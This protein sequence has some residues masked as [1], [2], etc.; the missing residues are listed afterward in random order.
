MRVNNDNSIGRLICF[1]GIDGSGKSTHL[2]LVRK[3]L[4]EKG[5]SVKALIL[6]TQRGE[7]F[8]CLEPL[9]GQIPEQLYCDLFMFQRYL[10][11]Q[12]RLRNELARNSVVLCDRFLFDDLPYTIGYGCKTDAMEFMLELAPK[13]DLAFLFDVPVEIA[14]ERIM[15]RKNV[16]S[17]Q[18]N[19]NLLERTRRA[20]LSMVARWNLRVINTN[21]KIERSFSEVMEH[22][23]N[24]LDLRQ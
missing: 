3:S 1:C 23:T 6:L 9:I 15:R 2:R 18:E 19:Y 16:W 13:P 7:F 14:I 20:Y 4:M 17:R 8:R 10:K 22:L 11:A 5:Y 21:S 12:T 24:T